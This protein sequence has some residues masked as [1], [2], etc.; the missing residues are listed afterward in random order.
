MIRNVRFEW[1]ADIKALRICPRA[2]VRMTDGQFCLALFVGLLAATTL[3]TALV[4]EG[5]NG[6]GCV[7]VPVTASVAITAYIV[8]FEPDPQAPIFLGLFYGVAAVAG[9]LGAIIGPAI[10]K[11]LR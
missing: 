7:A 5:R 10:R 11:R 3:V 9:A 1:K 4:G 8:M 2:V 6:L